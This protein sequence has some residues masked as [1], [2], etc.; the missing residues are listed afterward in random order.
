MVSTQ[1]ATLAFLLGLSTCWARTAT[2]TARHAVVAHPEVPPHDISD[3][4]SEE[5]ISATIVPDP[6]TGGARQ[7]TEGFTTT[8]APSSP[9]ETESRAEV[10]AVLSDKDP[11][12]ACPRREDIH[13]CTCVE[14]PGKA[15]DEIETV[16]L[17]RNIRNQKVLSDSMKGF[18]HHRID[19]F[20]L[21]SCKLPPFP[22]GLMHNVDVKWIEVL[23]TTVQFHNDFLTC[24]KG[25]F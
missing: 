19:Y 17:C 6:V 15:A 4:Y 14:V 11:R 25:C 5:D 23:N 13:P 10:P 16:A 9:P 3:I 24:S 2:I 22:N 18:Q 20:V 1:L 12:W 21:D 7:E 8:S